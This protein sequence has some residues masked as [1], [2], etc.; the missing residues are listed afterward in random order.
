[1]LALRRGKDESGELSVK[2][3]VISE[4]AV[5]ALMHRILELFQVHAKSSRVHVS[6]DDTKYKQFFENFCRTSRQSIII[7]RDRLI[8]EV[9]CE[10]LRCFL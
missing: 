5:V 3:S 10:A 8:G 6:L 1:M 2:V 9:C 7:D 4:S